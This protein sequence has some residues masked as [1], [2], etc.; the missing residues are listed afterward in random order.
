MRSSGP[1]K[2]VGRVWPRHSGRGRPL[3]SIVRHHM[4]GAPKVRSVWSGLAI[5]VLSLSIACVGVEGLVTGKTR[6]LSTYSRYASLVG[7]RAVISAFAYLLFA[8]SLFLF[9]L[10]CFSAE[11]TRRDALSKWGK[12]T[13]VASGVVLFS[14]L[15]FK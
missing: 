13:L 6:A 11:P 5:T 10:M 8:A 14:G 9:A 4:N 15:L 2:S 3:N 7:D 1:W 12:I